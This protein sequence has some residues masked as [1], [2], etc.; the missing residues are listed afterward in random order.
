[1]VTVGLL[2]AEASQNGLQAAETAVVAQ[3]TPSRT[4]TL[5]SIVDSDT[6]RVGQSGRPITVR[7]TC[8]DP[9]ERAQSPLRP[10]CPPVSADEAADRHA[11]GAR[12]R[13]HRP[14]RPQHGLDQT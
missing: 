6:I 3:F 4:D 8:I 5:L 14:L 1:M 7:L 9:P 2:L 11:G 12:Y 13:G 10:A